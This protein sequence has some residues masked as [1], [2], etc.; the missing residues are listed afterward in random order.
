MLRRSEQKPPPGDWRTWYIRGGRGSG[1]TR[2]GSETL[3]EWIRQNPGHEWAA[4][5]P[6]F[7]DARDVCI[8]GPSGLLAAFGLPRSY[9]GWNRSYGELFLPDASTVYC[10]GADD[11]A[12]RIQG[13]NLA[14]LW[15]DEVGLWR[16][17]RLAWEESIAYAVR[18]DPARIVATGTP[19]RGHP[20]VKK[21]LHDESIPTTRL[22]TMDNAANLSRRALNDLLRRYA[23]TTLGRQELEGEELEE[24]DGALWHRDM[25]RYDPPPMQPVKGEMVPDYLR[26]VVAID[27]AVTHGPDSDET[28]MVV[29]AVGPDR[30]GYL[31]AD[32]SGRYSPDEMRERATAAYEEY[33]A[34]SIIAEVNNGGD[35][36]ERVLRG[37]NWRGAYHS[38][39]A[40]RG[41]RTRAEPVSALYEQ[42]RV[43]HLRPFVEL[44][45]QLCTFTAESML[46][47]DRLD[48]LVWAFTE[49]MVDDTAYEGSLVGSN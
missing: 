13:R 18:I 42:G 22:R 40:S 19:K 29:A 25:I 15:A 36:V 47:P 8:E 28:G 4:V 12:L 7:G 26:V 27:P 2:A 46:S 5:A 3:A 9:K 38:V 17:W 41:K 20:L 48:A 37:K 21:L 23:D 31:I 16:Q 39:H 30:R 10:D 14:G 44:E 35:L 43:S 1:K 6:T 11:G 49:L 45:D 33:G 34:D 32:L 24:V